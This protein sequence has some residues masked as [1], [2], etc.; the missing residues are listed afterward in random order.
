MLVRHVLSFA[1][2][3]AILGLLS[4]GLLYFSYKFYIPW[5]GGSDY[6]EYYKMYVSPLDFSA[7]H[8]PWVYRQLS[9]ILTHVVYKSGLYYNDEISF[10]DLAYDQRIF[11][12]A[13]LTNFVCLLLTATIVGSSVERRGNGGLVVYPLL[14]GL[15]CFAS[16]MSQTAVITGLTDG[17]TWLLIAALVYFYLRESSLSAVGV[18]L[19]ISIFQREMIAVMFGALACFSLIFRRGTRRYQAAVLLFSVASFCTYVFIRKFLLP[20]PGEYE[21]Q[22]SV[23]SMLHAI[24]Q[25]RPTK[26]LIL[27]GMLSQN[28]LILCLLSSFILMLTGGRTARIMWVSLLTWAVLAGI[29]ILEGIGGNLG[30]VAGAMTPLFAIICTSTLQELEHRIQLNA[31]SFTTSSLPKPFERAQAAADGAKR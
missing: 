2:R 8:S 1:A 28:V 24:Q 11:F 22:L 30:R 9:A 15:L 5:Y 27:Q 18:L 25:F 13:L 16:F 3:L 29:S 6:I 14:A 19:A 20:V 21:G 12:A 31:G 4:Y 7:A 26:A 17:V 10:H 23:I